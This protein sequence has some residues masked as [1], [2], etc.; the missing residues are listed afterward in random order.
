MNIIGDTKKDAHKTPAPTELIDSISP[1][2]V[3][4]ARITIVV[5]YAISAALC[6]HFIPLPP[7]LLPTLPLSHPRLE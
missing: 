1:L 3:S 2:I 6:H 4:V 7:I 5:I